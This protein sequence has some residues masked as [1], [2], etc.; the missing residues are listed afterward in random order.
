MRFK[1][2]KAKGEGHLLNDS[3][4]NDEKIWGQHSK[5][6]TMSGPIAGKTYAITFMDHP[7]NLR[8]PTRWHAR[9][10]GLFAANPFCEYDMDKTKPKGSGDFTLKAGQSITLK[11]RI[12]ITQGDETALKQEDRFKEYAASVK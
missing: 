1:Q 4:V 3:G 2:P 6:V 10:Y 9:D 12:L 11:Y 7:S 8:H 5:W